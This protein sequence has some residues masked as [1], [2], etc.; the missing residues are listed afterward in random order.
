[1]TEPLVYLNGQL[2]PASQARLPIYD[3]GI[4]MGATVTDQ[5]RTFHQRL[6]RLGEH[7][8]RLFGSLAA[9][10][11]NI[12]LSKEELATIA[13]DLVA[14]HARQLDAVDELGIVFFVTA[15]E[16]RT[17]APVPHAA[18]GSGPTV[19]AH[20]FPLPFELWADKVERGTHLIT[21][22]IRQV[23]P[24]CLNPAMKC[25]SRMHYFLADREARQTDP[26]AS[27]LLL[28]LAGHVTET[29]TANF[30]MVEQGTIVS[31]TL[32]NTLTGVS[33]AI[34][35][36][37]AARLGIPFQERDI[38]PGQVACADEAFLASTPYCLMPVTRV[39]GADIGNGQPGITFRRLVDAWSQDVGLDIVRQM[40]DGAQRRRRSQASRS[41]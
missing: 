10:G 1:M 17:Y 26:D 20:T 16:Y 2:L 23:P 41:G 28:D 29:S 34:V 18:S 12:R 3:A 31:P 14:Y 37:L 6:Y 13:H 15:G 25:R 32:V 39:N 5:A 4:V 24:Q 40:A 35:A 38:T 22:S 30:L 9:A 19:C 8:D 33:R 21:P 7:L 27:A 36:Q 11:I